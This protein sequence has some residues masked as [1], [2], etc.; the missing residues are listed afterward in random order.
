MISKGFVPRIFARLLLISTLFL[1]N[2]VLAA[3]VSILAS[4]NRQKVAAGDIVAL[5][6]T[7]RGATSVS[8]PLFPSIDGLRL[9]STSVSSRITTGASGFQAE[10]YHLY[11]LQALK[12]GKFEIPPLEFKVGGASYTTQR[13]SVE[14]VDAATPLPSPAATRGDT[15]TAE[16][17]FLRAFT[18]I[19][20]AYVGQQVPV[21]LQLCWAGVRISN[22]RLSL[23]EAKGFRRVSL[24][25][26]VQTFRT[27][28]GSQY[29]VL[30]LT[31]IY[32]PLVPGKLRIGPFHIA[33][34]LLVSRK[35]AQR[36]PASVDDFFD[37]DIDTLFGSYVRKPVNVTANAITIDVRPIPEDAKPESFS[38]AVG[39]FSVLA[40]VKPTD[41][42]VGDGV[43]ITMTVHGEGELEAATAP[44]VQG[45]DAL[46]A[47][48]PEI[49]YQVLPNTDRLHTQKI[50]KQLVIVQ[51]ADVREIPTLEFSYFDPAVGDYRKVN[52]GPFPIN[53]TAAEPSSQAGL[54]RPISKRNISL[55]SR[56][57]FGIRTDAVP[58]V[59]SPRKI[60]SSPVLFAVV[61]AIPALVA[62]ISL[63]VSRRC[64]R[65]RIDSAY[66]RAVGARKKALGGLKG[67]DAADTDICSKVARALCG[68]VADKLD[69][70]PSSVTADSIEAILRSRGATLELVSE[71]LATLRVCDRG[72]F[73]G[74]ATESEETANLLATAH[75]LIQKL[76]KALRKK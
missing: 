41:V 18:D 20:E 68:L 35:S 44:L 24:S 31:Q 16:K 25:E 12:A 63:V 65:L 32:F 46:R 67:A 70:S 47:F 73:S 14:V 7:I 8:P 60:S 62:S 61:L 52:R 5:T 50:F 27:I 34:D 10:V 21:T 56:G 29:N 38:A 76:D 57:L 49:S 58:L 71:V 4:V 48:P 40:D 33:C 22:P 51:D 19:A 72:R 39:R 69:L 9:L 6:V 15:A 42:N 11:N 36:W 45:S 43:T 54:R 74:R 53:V 37:A 66:A 26:P 55:L 23:V 2:S 64:E 75:S 17:L 3:D 30:E 28:G 59:R 13:V 1:C